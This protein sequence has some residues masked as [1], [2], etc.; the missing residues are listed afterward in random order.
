MLSLYRH[1]FVT[2]YRRGIF[3]NEESGHFPA[4]LRRLS[5]IQSVICNSDIFWKE[6][7]Q[8]SAP[9]GNQQLLLVDFHR[10]MINYCIR[11]KLHQ[12]LY[13]YLDYWQLVCLNVCRASCLTVQVMLLSI[14]FCFIIC[15]IVESCIFQPVFGKYP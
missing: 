12:L 3:W 9:A 5:R 11:S 6:E 8:P 4:L 13:F 15:F 10:D 14:M 2:C 7:H 1:I